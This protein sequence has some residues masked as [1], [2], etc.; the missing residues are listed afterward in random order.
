MR[1]ADDLS[2]ISVKGSDKP[3]GYVVRPAVGRR[4]RNWPFMARTVAWL[5][6]TDWLFQWH[7]WFGVHLRYPMTPALRLLIAAGA[8]VAIGICSS[9]LFPKRFQYALNVILVLAW[10]LQC[11]F[12]LFWPVTGVTYKGLRLAFSWL[13]WLGNLG[14]VGKAVTVVTVAALAVVAHLA[15]AKPWYIVLLC[16]LLLGVTSLLV[17]IWD[18]AMRPFYLLE[19]QCLM[20]IA[21]WTHVKNWLMR[22]RQ[23][24][25]IH[26][27]GSAHGMLRVVAAGLILSGGKSALRMMR[28]LDTAQSRLSYVLHFLLQTAVTLAV[29]VVGLAGITATVDGLASPRGLNT[30]SQMPGQSVEILLAVTNARFPE[31]VLTPVT[32][33]SAPWVV[34][35]LVGCYLLVGVVLAFTMGVSSRAQQ[36]AMDLRTKLDSSRHAALVAIRALLRGTKIDGLWRGYRDE[37]TPPPS[38]SA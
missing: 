6:L 18:S 4:R 27:E 10:P 3:E 22:T 24:R 30:L 35:A 14:L 2:L 15:V 12:K 25:Y 31:A 33:R 11:V 29:T 32:L 23:C 9:L 38:K 1:P 20:R 19:Q 34:S 16:L 37:L 28:D 13:G 8:M 26:V 21:F 36:D 5:G 17:G 7:S